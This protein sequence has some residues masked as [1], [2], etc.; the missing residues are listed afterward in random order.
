M[1]KEEK[2]DKVTKDFSLLPEAKQDYVLGVVQ[3][4][5]FAH[6]SGSERPEI[7]PLDLGQNPETVG[8]I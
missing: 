1:T 4:L 8:R 6:D 3:A 5:A 2:L 7:V